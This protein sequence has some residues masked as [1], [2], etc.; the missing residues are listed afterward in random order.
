MIESISAC[1]G[2][3]SLVQ[4]SGSPLRGDARSKCAFDDGRCT[5]SVFQVS[6]NSRGRMTRAKGEIVLLA[7]SIFGIQG[8]RTP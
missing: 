8:R 2:R 5:G 4:F 7:R 3:I 6:G 1:S